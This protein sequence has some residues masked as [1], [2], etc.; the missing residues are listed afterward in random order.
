MPMIIVKVVGH[1][2]IGTIIE[3]GS[4]MNIIINSFRIQLGLQ[5]MQITPYI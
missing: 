4:R 2:V 1:K 5:G 3:G